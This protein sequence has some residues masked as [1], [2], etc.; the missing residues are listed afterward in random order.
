MHIDKLELDYIMNMYYRT[1]PG[2]AKVNVI[3]KVSELVERYEDRS[4]IIANEFIYRMMDGGFPLYL[5][6]FNGL[7]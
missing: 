6:D 4:D 7:D 2:A 1:Y 5:S 3:W